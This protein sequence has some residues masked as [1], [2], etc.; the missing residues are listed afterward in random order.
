MVL[1]YEGF[2]FF[3]STIPEWLNELDSSRPYWPSS[4]FGDEEDPN[5]E[6]SGNRH[7]WDIWSFWVDYSEVKHDESLFVTEF[8][9][10]APAT[11]ET[12]KNVLPA[13]ALYSQSELFEFHNKQDEGSERLF[14]FLSGHLPVKTDLESFREELITWSREQMAAFKYPRIIEFRDSL[15]MTATG[16]ILKKELKAELT[17]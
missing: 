2:E 9:F 16:K 10:Q 11:Y 5:S 4:P 14:R 1:V 13:S 7:V 12:F 3:H 8:G 17:G 6:Q 15:P